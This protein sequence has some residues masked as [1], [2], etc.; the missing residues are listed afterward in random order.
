[1]DHIWEE[2]LY[3]YQKIHK[4]L[5]KREQIWE[6]FQNGVMILFF[7]AHGRSQDP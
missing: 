7:N 2:L 5:M 1:M 3:S 6:Y 4:I